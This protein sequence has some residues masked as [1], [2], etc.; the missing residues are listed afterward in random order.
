MSNYDILTYRVDSIAEMNFEG[1]QSMD[2]RTPGLL[3]ILP[4]GD[5]E[6]DGLFWVVTALP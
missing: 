1:L 3:L 2:N 6:E 5:N 4:Q